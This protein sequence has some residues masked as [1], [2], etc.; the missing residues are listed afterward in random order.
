MIQKIIKVNFFI[1]FLATISWGEIV[2][3]IIVDGNKRISKETLIIFSELSN[4]SD[5]SQE[6]LSEALKKIYATNFFKTVN[7][8]IENSILKITVIENPI[9]SG[10]EV[11]GIRSAKLLDYILEKI[12]LKNRSSFIE[13]KFQN[14]LVFVNNILKSAGYYF[15]VIDTKSILNEEQNSINIIY[16]IDLGEKAKIDQIQFLNFGNFYHN[17]FI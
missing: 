15:A 9:I 17:L 7:L 1:L 16:D 3:D 10:V 13:S 2:T 6:E 11:N 4:G 14:D 8:S 5:Y 12:S